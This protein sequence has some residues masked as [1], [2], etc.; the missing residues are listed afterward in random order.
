SVERLGYAAWLSLT[1]AATETEP[2]ASRFE[3]EP[4][5][6]DVLRVTVGGD[7]TA[8]ARLLDDFSQESVSAEQAQGFPFAPDWVLEGST[9]PRNVALPVPLEPT[10][11]GY[12]R[13][14]LTPVQRK[15]VMAFKMVCEAPVSYVWSVA[16]LDESGKQL[17]RVPVA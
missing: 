17:S 2:G 14:L 13:V 1:L 9:L 3:A 10:G 11:S 4:D 16:R 7:V 6:L 8:L 5:L 12:V 15:Q